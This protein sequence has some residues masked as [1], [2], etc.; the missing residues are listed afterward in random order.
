MRGLLRFVWWSLLGQRERLITLSLG[1]CCISISTTLLA[2]Y[3]QLSTLTADQQISRSW[4]TA[5]DLLVRA[6]DA[7]SPVERQLHL[8][9]PSAPE[10]TYGGISLAQVATISHIEHVD[11]AAPEAIVGWL[12][13]HPYLPVTFTQPGL[14]RVTT[15]LTDAVQ[16][17]QSQTIFVALPMP[18]YIAIAGAGSAAGV[19]YIPLNAAGV[20]TVAA[21]WT[22]TVLLAGIDPVAERQLVGL[23]WQPN[24]AS[25][26]AT[27]LPLLMDT[28]PW[29]PL[30]ATLTV[31]WAPL[32]AD[33]STSLDISANFASSTAW[34]P[35]SRQQ[36]DAAGLL[37]LLARELRETDALSAIAPLQGGGVAR[38][39]RAA[40]DVSTASGSD[41]APPVLALES[42]GADAGGPLVRLPL[43]PQASSPWV[44][45]SGA[46]GS[47]STFDA[48]SLPGLRGPAPQSAPLGLYRPEP[49]GTLPGLEPQ[50]S[51]IPWPPLLFTTLPMACA[52]TG[53]RCVS[54]VRVRVAGLGAFGERSEALLQQAAAAIEAQTGLHVDVLAGA[55]GRPVLVHVPG[56]DG[57]VRTIT[58]IWIQ[59]HAAVVIA[60]GVNGANVLLLL[61]AAGVAG[62][63]LVAAALLAASSRRRDV[64]LLAQTGWSNGWLI[65]ESALEAAAA[66]L[67]AIL[68]AW[69]LSTILIFL[70]AP[71]VSPQGVLALLLLAAVFY[72]TVAAVT[73]GL[74][75]APSAKHGG[76]IRWSWTHG[77]WW[78]ALLRRQLR[79]RRGGAVLVL[80]AMAGGCGLVLLLALVRWGL[81]GVLYATLLGR[82]VQVGLSAI[83]L[84][85]ALLTCASAALTA[86]LILLLAIRER[87][88]EFGV[89][90]A[91][92]WTGRDVAVQVVREGLA[93]GA[94]GGA[95]G[96]L[97]A[98]LVFLVIYHTAS[99]L[100]FV[101]WFAAPALGALLC[102]AG[103]GYPA[104]Q[105]SR[106]PVARI[107][108]EE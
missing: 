98:E 60:H 23:S 29:A 14:Y 68:P 17:P 83:H 75:L 69:A 52:L 82:E 49:V 87:R 103:A 46:S 21:A 18:Q 84:V 48:A 107:L 79:W 50:Q 7:L 27:G 37:S 105:A 2:G 74:G 81:D 42:V 70:G 57:R 6:P 59:P 54:A 91:T 25:A 19:A 35:V 104:F 65:F 73:I 97:L 99:P 40:Y 16:S 5:Y 12:R 77:P 93:L 39:G 100:L 41:G 45:L 53:E 72:T 31:E 47:L 102:A 56:A 20:A 28:H 51:I 106:L 55:S 26:A 61:A 43:L 94:L 1:L 89:L 67:L 88:R 76:N 71:P 62:L 33:L 10:Q 22:I 90:L 66:C 15:E 86:G 36:L 34:V 92:G 8:V 78:W 9:D 85:I 108:T 96:M 38:Y 95:C 30:A 44:A 32:P 13:L 64:L 58:E 80:A 63:A 3:T 24:A 101:G 11:V 4:R